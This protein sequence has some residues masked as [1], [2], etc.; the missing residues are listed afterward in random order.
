MRSLTGGGPPC[1]TW[2]DSVRVN[3]KFYACFSLGFLILYVCL[4]A[5]VCTCVCTRVCMAVKGRGWCWESSLVTLSITINSSSS[6]GDR[7]S[8]WIWDRPIWVDWLTCDSRDPF[9]S[10]LSYRYLS[11]TCLAFFI[12]SHVPN[13]DPHASMEGILSTESHTSQ[14][15]HP[16]LDFFLPTEPYLYSSPLDF[17]RFLPILFSPK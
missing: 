11:A 13:P 4:C 14:T 3:I 5:C 1:S 9:V 15:P 12:R 16:H 6:I 8:H 17:L 10:T 7:L 2:E